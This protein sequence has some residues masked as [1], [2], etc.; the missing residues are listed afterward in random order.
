MVDQIRSFDKESRLVKKL[1]TLPG[2]IMEQ[3]E[4]I[5]SQLVEIPIK[6]KI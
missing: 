4:Q 6:P 1:G 5:L 3:A 2:E